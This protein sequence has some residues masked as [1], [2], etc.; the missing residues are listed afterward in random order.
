MTQVQLQLDLPSSGL[1]YRVHCRS[2]KRGCGGLLLGGFLYGG[3]LVGS[4]AGSSV[5]VRCEGV[6]QLLF[7]GASDPHA[8]LLASFLQQRHGQLSQGAVLHVGPQLLLRNLRARLLFSAAATI[9]PCWTGGE[10]RQSLQLTG[11][12]FKTHSLTSYELY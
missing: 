12:E 9:A 7:L 5:E 11:R 1:E 2:L 6:N 3:L 10:L 8:Q 4:V